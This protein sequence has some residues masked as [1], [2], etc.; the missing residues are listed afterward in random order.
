[1]NKTPKA[2]DSLQH[3]RIALGSFYMTESMIAETGWRNRALAPYPAGWY[4]FEPDFTP[5]GPFDS[6]QIA[7]DVRAGRLV[8][9][10]FG[11]VR[12]K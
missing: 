7:I 2:E 10:R 8:P 1:M 3:V 4:Y 12:G 6:Q 11:M 9:L 5:Q